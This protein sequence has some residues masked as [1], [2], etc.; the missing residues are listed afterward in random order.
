LENPHDLYGTRK[1]KVVGRKKK[2]KTE[3]QQIKVRR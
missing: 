1:A 2:E 3:K